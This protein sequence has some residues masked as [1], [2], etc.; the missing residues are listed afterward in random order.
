MYGGIHIDTKKYK[1]LL[2][3]IDCGSL[4]KAGEELGYTQSGVSHMIKN[5]EKKWDLLY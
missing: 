2:R 5:L 1:V 3:A 4:T